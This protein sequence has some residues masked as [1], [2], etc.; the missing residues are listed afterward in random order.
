[1]AFGTPQEPCGSERETGD[2]DRGQSHEQIPT[3]ET[4][5][6]VDLLKDNQLEDCD[7]RCDDTDDPKELTVSHHDLLRAV[8]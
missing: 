3:P 7:E 8:E 1:M 2:D 6:R 5:P 4:K